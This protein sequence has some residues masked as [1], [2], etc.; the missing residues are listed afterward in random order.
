MLLVLAL[1]CA[2]PDDRAKVAPV[3]SDRPSAPSATPVAQA[4]ATTP[5]NGLAPRIDA[6]SE[7][8]AGTPIELG[9][10]LANAGPR[11]LRIFWIE[12]EGFRAELSQVVLLRA[13]G[14]PVTP[15]QVSRGHG[16]VVGEKD[17]PRL[18]PG[19]ERRATQ[20]IATVGLPPGAYQV[21]WSYAN[22]TDRWTG[23]GG[24]LDGPGTPLFGGGP[25]PEIWLGEVS[26]S[27]SVVIKADPNAPPSIG[28]A[29]I[30]RDGTITLTL[31]ATD[32]KGAVGDGQIVYARTHPD[33]DKVRAHTGLDTV[34]V[35][36]EVR[37][38]PKTW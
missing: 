8:L 19:E 14:S 31:R 38:F 17:F 25:I 12:V 28:T 16:Y 34:G 36:V 9:L 37:P 29:T 10:V 33:Y 2:A 7:V 4:A 21:R 15:P 30:A 22:G 32:G 3:P 20:R 35:V 27:A 23:A 6:P 5:V 11:P 18:A 26:A 13:D 24:T 1:G